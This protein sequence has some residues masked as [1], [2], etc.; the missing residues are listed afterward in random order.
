M[1][2]KKT[3]LDLNG[4]IDK[5]KNDYNF[6]I[7]DEKEIKEILKNLNYYKLKGYMHPLIKKSKTTPINFCEVIDTFHFD[8]KLRLL[9]FKI[10]E[11]I[12]ISLKAKVALKIGNVIGGFGYNDSSYFK[13]SLGGRKYFDHTNFLKNIESYQQRSK[14]DFIQHYLRKYSKSKYVPLWMM[15]ELL[16]FGDLSR[17][18]EAYKKNKDISKEYDLPPDILISWLHRL[19]LIRNY[20]AH[21]SRVWNRR[22]NNVSLKKEWKYHSWNYLE[23]T[24][25]FFKY[26]MNYINPKFSFLEIKI[27]IEDFITKYPNKAIDMGIDKPEKLKYLV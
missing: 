19:S 16:P 23:G 13:T 17:F 3:Y 25:Y 8:K 20:C 6:I 5:I 1:E 4:Q 14:E 22:Y 11:E 27:H 2:Y 18:Y 9:I 7:D 24:L 15:V 12:E 26:I 21:N 10:L